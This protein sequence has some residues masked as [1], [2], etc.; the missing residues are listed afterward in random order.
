MFGFL[1]LRMYVRMQME[2]ESSPLL[3]LPISSIKNTILKVPLF[4][5]VTVAFPVTCN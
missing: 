3:E 1:N 5:T 4:P 2:L